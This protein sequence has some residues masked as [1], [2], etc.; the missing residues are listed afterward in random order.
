M[1]LYIK[2]INGVS[3]DHPSVESNLLEVFGGVIP[4]EYELFETTPN[5]LVRGVF[6]VAERTYIKRNDGVWTDSWTIRDMTDSEKAD[7]TVK[8]VKDTERHMT[9]HKEMAQRGI[10]ACLSGSDLDGVNAWSTYLVRCNNWVLQSLDPLTPPMPRP[11][12]KNVLGVWVDA[13]LR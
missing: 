11:P 13:D 10:A 7:E 3:I 2:V 4:S 5:E 1:K 12:Y 9:F 8:L 6:Q